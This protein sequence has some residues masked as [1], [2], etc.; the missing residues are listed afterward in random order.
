MFL[1]DVSQSMTT[2]GTT[3]TFDST[4]DY[5]GKFKELSGVDSAYIV[6]TSY[7]IHYTK[8]YDFNFRNKFDHIFSATINLRVPLLAPE[9]FHFTHGHAGYRGRRDSLVYRTAGGAQAAFGRS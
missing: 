5:I 2:A 6:I 3:L 8:L 1:F 7:S 9:P 4:F